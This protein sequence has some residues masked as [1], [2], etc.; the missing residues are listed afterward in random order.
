MFA[1][2]VSI[3]LKSNML[4][5]YTRTFE[6]DILPLLRRQNGFKDEITFAGPGGVDVTAISLWENKT[7]AEAYNTNTYPEVLKTMARFIEGTPKV[8]TS[9]VVTSTCHK[10]AVHAAA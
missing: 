3:H 4:S 7:D 10:I 6:K 1:R 8:Q 2:N 5:D 9:D